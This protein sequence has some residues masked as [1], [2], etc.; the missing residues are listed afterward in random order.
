VGWQKQFRT[1]LQR[2]Y[3]RRRHALEHDLRRLVSLKGLRGQ[4]IRPKPE[5]IPEAV[6]ALKGILL[7]APEMRSRIE[8][9]FYRHTRGGRKF[10]E[11]RFLNRRY[12]RMTE[13][14]VDWA[15][16]LPGSLVY[17]FWGNGRCLYVGRTQNGGGR[18]S[19]HRKEWWF[20]ERATRVE[21]YLPKDYRHL[22]AL[23]CLGIH[24]LRP[25]QN[26]NRAARMGA[27]FKVCPVCSGFEAFEEQVEAA[28]GG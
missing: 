17:V 23:E 9:E 8:E 19:Q 2:L 6:E 25:T 7:R 12:D 15:K 11:A 28:F 20:K 13:Q 27:P 18:P 21:A 16:D 4:P 22:A 1:T 5:E 10:S 26:E 14:V 3:E 24:Y